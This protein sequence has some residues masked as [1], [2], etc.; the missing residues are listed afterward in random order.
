M[1][2]KDLTGIRIGKLTVMEPTKERV[3]RLVVWK[4]QCDCGNTVDVWQ[5]NLQKGFTTSCGCRRDP[6]K[7]MHYVEGTCVESLRTDVMYKSNTSGGP[8]RVLQ[9]KKKEMDCADH[10]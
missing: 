10:V 4:C 8:R 3:H 7:N 9:Q 1:K 2:G 6:S 5:S